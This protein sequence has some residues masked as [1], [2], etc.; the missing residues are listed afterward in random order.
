MGEIDLYEYA[1]DSF[2]VFFSHPRDY[3][4]GRLLNVTTL[5]GILPSIFIFFPAQFSVCTTELGSM[6][7]M[8]DEFA[9]Y[10]AKLVGLSVDSVEDHKGEEPRDSAFATLSE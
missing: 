2:L 6:A 1:G 5:C 3:T 9:K 8:C 7:K 4:P 10:G